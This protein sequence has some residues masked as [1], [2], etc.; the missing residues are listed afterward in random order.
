MFIVATNPTFTAPVTANIPAD[1]GK[2]TKAK[3]NIIFKALSKPEVDE[4]L[5]SIRERA[6]AAVRAAAAEANGEKAE[7]STLLTDRE[8]LDTVLAG[9][10]P[11]LVEEDRTPMQ[12]TPANVD[13]LCAIYPIESAIVKSFFENYVNGP[14]K[15]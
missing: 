13:R 8:I 9:F 1:G 3:F 15:N 6:K 11:D 12:Y 4:L 14:A 7:E 5:K 2:Y 10:G